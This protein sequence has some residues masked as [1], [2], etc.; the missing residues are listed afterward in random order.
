MSSSSYDVFVVFSVMILQI[1]LMIKYQKKKKKDFAE[2]LRWCLKGCDNQSQDK[3]V[4]TLNLNYLKN[5]ENF[6]ICHKV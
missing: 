6:D 1:W 3:K 4:L 5:F 2:G